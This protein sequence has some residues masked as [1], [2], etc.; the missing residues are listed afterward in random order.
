MSTE[1]Q[2]TANRRNAL[3]STGPKSAD[4][5]LRASRN[6]IKHGINSQVTTLFNERQEDYDANIQA[7]V[8]KFQPQ[9]DVERRL[10]ERLADCEWRLIRARYIETA[11]IDLQVEETYELIDERFETIQEPARV[12]YAL[13]LLDRNQ[14]CAYENV[15]RQE[16]R[17]H[18]HY[19]RA[20]KTLRE[21]QKNTPRD[22]D[23]THRKNTQNEANF[24]A[25]PA[26]PQSQANEANR[27]G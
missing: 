25:S 19:E 4:G 12:A 24:A 2:I 26:H 17:L 27:A 6:A 10:V 22:L 8:A 1:A 13:Q 14:A 16:A 11:T 23:G 3:R 21:I 9:D 20:Y 18:R 5:K 15:Q 7:F